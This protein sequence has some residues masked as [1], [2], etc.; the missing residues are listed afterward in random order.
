MK[1]N[2]ELGFISMKDKKMLKFFE[3]MKVNNKRWLNSLKKRNIQKKS[4]RDNQ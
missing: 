1:W 3:R 2:E 4:R